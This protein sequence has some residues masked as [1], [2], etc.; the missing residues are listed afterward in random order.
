MGDADVPPGHKQVLHVAT[1]KA[2]VRRPIRPFVGVDAAVG[3]TSNEFR[4]LMAF[5][6]GQPLLVI[7]PEMMTGESAINET[8]RYFHKAH[9]KKPPTV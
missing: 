3:K 8:F 7:K 4:A 5:L 9:N 1:V 6:K 2:P